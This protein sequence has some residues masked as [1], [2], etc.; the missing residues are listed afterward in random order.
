MNTFTIYIRGIL[1]NVRGTCIILIGIAAALTIIPTIIFAES[2]GKEPYETDLAYE[3]RRKKQAKILKLPKIFMPIG[4][5]LL[6]MQAL[7]PSSGTFAAMT[8]IPG[9]ANS[10]VI[11]KDLPDLY[12]AAMD[13]LKESLGVEKKVEK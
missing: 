10:D 9:I 7:I 12:Q 13:K 5:I 4:F 6:I 8:I 2:S 11:K 3:G 1:D